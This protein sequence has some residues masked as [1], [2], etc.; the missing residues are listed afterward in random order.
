MD[1]SD[2]SKLD[3]YLKEDEG[4][5]YEFVVTAT[6]KYGESSKTANIQKVKVLKGR[7]KVTE[8]DV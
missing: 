4:M 6:N 5:E 2:T 8:S 1:I 3:Y 7:V